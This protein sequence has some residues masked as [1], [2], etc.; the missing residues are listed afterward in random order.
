MRKKV[1]YFFSHLTEKRLFEIREDFIV[2]LYYIQQYKKK[3]RNDNEYIANKLVTPFL[4]LTLA[5]FVS[6]S[7]S[8]FVPLRSELVPMKLV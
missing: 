7:P 4:K 3:S 1:Q 5:P 2:V 6:P 8:P